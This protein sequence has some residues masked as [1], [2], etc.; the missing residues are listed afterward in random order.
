VYKFQN[1]LNTAFGQIT[2]WFQVNSLFLNLSISYFIQFFTKSLNYSDTNITYENNQIPKVNDIKFLALHINNTLS[3]KTHIDNIV[4]KSRSAGF[5]MRSVKPYVSQKMLKMIYSVYFHSITS[6]GKMSW[7]HSASS[8]RVFGLQKRIIRITI[9]CRS[10]DS[11]RKLFIRLKI[12][13]LP[14]LYILSLFLFVI[15]NEELFTTNNEIHSICTRQHLNF[16]QPSANLTKYQTGMY[17]VGL[18][19]FNPLNPELNPICYLLALLG[20][21]HFL[22]V[23]RIRVK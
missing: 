18:Q 1:D 14:S 12:F 23:S 19:I 20:A 16:Y 11:C 4:L 22:H 5:A 10:R 17:Y 7:D 6:Y 15:K 2:K 21:H 3:W 9:R 13:P 8:R